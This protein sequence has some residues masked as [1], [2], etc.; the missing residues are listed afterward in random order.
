ML[1]INE[2]EISDVNQWSSSTAMKDYIEDSRVV[3]RTKK[4]F[5]K[6]RSISQGT[7]DSNVDRTES[8][9]ELTAK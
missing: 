1:H 8:K 7:D 4:L 3:S 9:A 6:I 2:I 5:N